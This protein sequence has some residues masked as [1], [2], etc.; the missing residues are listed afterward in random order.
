VSNG[1]ELAT[2]LASVARIL[3]VEPDVVR[4]LQRVCDL[5]VETID[6]CDHADVMV[7]TARSTPTVPGASDWVG[8]RIVSIESEVDQGPCLEAT[9]T[10]SVVPIED[11]TQDVRWAE[12]ARR[13]LEETPVRSSVGVPLIA[14]GRTL[15]AIDVY[16]D[17]V[18]AFSPDDVAAATLFAAHAAIALLAVKTREELQAAL[19]SRD[20]IGQAKG[21]IMATQRVTSD[22]AFDLLRRASQRMNVKLVEVAGQIVSAN[23]RES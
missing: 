10:G 20:L 14:G 4:L 21:I 22:E 11:L 12:F 13:C 17:Q 23:T 18:R 6:A 15:G 5:A 2:A 19:L 8:P 16:A 1:D 9:R 3:S 7:M